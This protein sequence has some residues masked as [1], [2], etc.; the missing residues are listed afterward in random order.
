MDWNDLRYFLAVAQGGSLSSAAQQLGVSVSTVS[1]RIDTLEQ[2]LKLRL[3]R[4]HRDGYDLTPDGQ[5]L[6]P[7]ADQAAAEM[8]HFERKAKGADGRATPVRIEAPEL[9]AQ[10]LLMPAIAAFM[11]DRPEIR[12]ELRGSALPIRLA[13][14][15]ADLILRLVRPEKG[16]YRIQKVGQ[17]TFGLYASP[18]HVAIAGRPEQLED[19]RRH[20]I[21]GW[22]DDLGYLLMARWLAQ[23]CPAIE[24]HLRLTSLSAQM[25]AAKR[26][27]GWAAL[28]DFAA[29]PAGLVPAPLYTPPLRPDL[30]LLTHPNADQRSEVTHIQ[31]AIKDAL[32][33]L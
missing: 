11:Q 13:S 19:L 14:Q 7:A 21:I 6:L 24:P 3:F 2:S 16:N 33:V 30:W 8:R 22:P 10:D 5:G 18:E 26:G 23:L 25:A 29:R 32:A 9:I 28:P 15:E 17:V 4:P 20:R 31:A 12:I 27:L 1:R